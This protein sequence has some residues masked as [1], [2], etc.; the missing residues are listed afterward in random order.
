MAKRPAWVHGIRAGERMIGLDEPLPWS[1]GVCGWSRRSARGRGQLCAG[2]AP[3]TGEA[4]A[5]VRA[6]RGQFETGLRQ[7]GALQERLTDEA[8][9]LDPA[10]DA[11]EA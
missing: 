8:T 5:Q 1:D 2:A 6:L 4:A 7:I 11:E 3:T 9:D 10:P